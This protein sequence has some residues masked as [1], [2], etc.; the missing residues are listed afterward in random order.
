[1]KTIAN[2][3]RPTLFTLLVLVLLATGLGMMT[4]QPAQSVCCDGWE[5][6]T[7]YWADASHTV[8]CG[9]CYTDCSGFTSCTGQTTAYWTRTRTCCGACF[10]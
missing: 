5:V 2:A 6:T 4:P 1:M 7:T 3:H 8:W 10:P 9:E